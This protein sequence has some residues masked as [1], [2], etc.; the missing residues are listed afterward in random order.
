M[1]YIEFMCILVC[2]QSETRK[3]Y[4]T[5]MEE[6]SENFI[7]DLSARSK[8]LV[9]SFRVYSFS[10]GSKLMHYSVFPWLLFCIGLHFVILSIS[11]GLVV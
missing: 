9:S 2:W 5:L 7:L 11:V 6:D 10:C 4:Q 3:M 8:N 1:H